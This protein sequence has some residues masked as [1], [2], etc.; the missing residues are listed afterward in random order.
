MMLGSEA[1]TALANARSSTGLLGKPELAA[2]LE[3]ELMRETYEQL[4]EH[5]S[6]AGPD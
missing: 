2:I 6:P 1:R 3:R 5:P 4:R